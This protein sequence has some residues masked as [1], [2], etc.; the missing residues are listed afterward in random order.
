MSPPVTRTGLT[1]LF[2]PICLIQSTDIIWFMQDL[3]F[4]PQLTI[5]IVP[6]SDAKQSQSNL[7]NYLAPNTL[8][9]IIVYYHFANNSS[10]CK[11]W[12]TIW[13]LQ[14][15]KWNN[16]A[17]HTFEVQLW[18]CWH[19]LKYITSKVVIFITTKSITLTVLNF[20]CFPSVRFILADVSE[21]SVRSIFK[22]LKLAP[23]IYIYFYT[24]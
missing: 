18:M 14:I 12:R 1:F 2:F 16:W 13:H 6:W 15:F 17:I 8:G 5:V 9:L 4:S 3:W 10:V 22:G 20:G 21:P 19:T 7:Q 23:Y 24:Q 11:I